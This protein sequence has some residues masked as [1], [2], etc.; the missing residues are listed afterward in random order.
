MYWQQSP[1]SYHRCKEA[2]EVYVAHPGRKDLSFLK[3]TR[4]L[5][6]TGHSLRPYVTMRENQF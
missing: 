2:Q 4:G 3:G 6:T 5:A 1:N